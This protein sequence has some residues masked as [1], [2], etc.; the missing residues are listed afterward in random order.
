[1]FSSWIAMMVLGGQNPV[2][3]LVDFWL[4]DF[5]EGESVC[6][7]VCLSFRRLVSSCVAS[8]HAE[9]QKLGDLSSCHDEHELASKL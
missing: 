4:V 5:S 2:L 8:L 1:M 6:L 7:S 9:M 3:W